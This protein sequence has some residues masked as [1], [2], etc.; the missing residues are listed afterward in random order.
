MPE[1]IKESNLVQS[2]KTSAAGILPGLAML[3]NHLNDVM[4]SGAAWDFNL[5]MTA[6]SII[7]MGS[8]AKEK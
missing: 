3:T 6:V 4:N 8:V 7:F 5:L 1:V 2:W